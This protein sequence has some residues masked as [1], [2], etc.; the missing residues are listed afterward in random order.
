MIRSWSRLALSVAGWAVFGFAITLV[1]T[2]VV[3]NASGRQSLTVMSGSME[4]TI[5]TGDVV[6]AKPIAP[7]D[8]RVG[9]VVTYK[10]PHGEG[11]LITHRVKTMQALQDKVRFT[12]QG[13][14]NDTSER[15][16]VATTGQIARVTH[17]IPKLGYGLGFLRDPSKRLF[18]IAIPA[19]LLGVFELARIWRPAP[20]E[21][22]GTS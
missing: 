2:L 14:A 13:D 8:A 10:E 3:A 18:L 4:P 20:P 5:D 21:T 12:T 16:Q 19:L 15:W 7:M 22:Q 9:D 6:V 17:R 1:V 11:R